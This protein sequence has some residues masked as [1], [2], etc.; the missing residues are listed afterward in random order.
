MRVGIGKKRESANFQLAGS[1]G[2]SMMESGFH[3]R[4]E[5]RGDEGSGIGVGGHGEAFECYVH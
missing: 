1:P 4:S 5:P 2:E 3:G